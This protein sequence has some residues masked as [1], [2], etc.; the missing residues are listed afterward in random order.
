MEASG[1]SEILVPMSPC[2]T[3]DCGLNH[4]CLLHMR[5]YYC[6]VSVFCDN[7]HTLHTP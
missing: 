6:I 5:L 3:Y 4:F 7:P 1:S 2:L